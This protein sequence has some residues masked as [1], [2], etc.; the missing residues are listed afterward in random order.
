[1]KLFILITMLGFF[2]SHAS[3]AIVCE[4]KTKWGS[5][6]KVSLDLQ[7]KEAIVE[8]AA[9]GSP[10]VYQNLSVYWDGH[11]TGLVTA[12]VFSMSYENH[13]GC[14]RNVTLITATQDRG[15]INTA[16]FANCKGEARHEDLCSR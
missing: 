1:M 10:K 15:A 3:A 2:S 8:T 4:G 13:F 14:I 7:K 9:L 16:I 6:I 11:L 12:E 5:D